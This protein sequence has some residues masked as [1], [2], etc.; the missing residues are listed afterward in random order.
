M[1]MPP[2]IKMHQMQRS[3]SSGDFSATID[4]QIDTLKRSNSSSLLDY[5]TSLEPE[6]KTKAS[7]ALSQPTTVAHNRFNRSNAEHHCFGVLHDTIMKPKP[8]LD[9]QHWQK[10]V[11]QGISREKYLKT[12]KDNAKKTIEKFERGWDRKGSFLKHEEDAEQWERHYR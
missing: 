3:Y 8:S 4:K 10:S 5:K 11:R 12:S 9:P 1:N 2:Y 6:S 7:T